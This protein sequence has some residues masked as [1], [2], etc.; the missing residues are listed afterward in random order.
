MVRLKPNYVLR[1]GPAKA[2]HYVNY[3]LRHGPARAAHQ[4]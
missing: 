3:V 4:Y 1:H 2:G